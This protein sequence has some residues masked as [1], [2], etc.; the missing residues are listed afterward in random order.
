MGGGGQRWGGTFQRFKIY[1]T[2][3]NSYD[4]VVVS[5]NLMFSHIFFNLNLN[6][7]GYIMNFE[8][9][10]VQIISWHGFNEK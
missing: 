8:G 6:I 10:S 4:K 1:M 2:L 9:K 3:W 5:L 7:E